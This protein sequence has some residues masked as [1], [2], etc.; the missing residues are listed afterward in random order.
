MHCDAESQR[1]RSSFI[2]EFVSCIQ[3]HCVLQNYDESH[4]LKKNPTYNKML[5]IQKGITH[6]FP[7]E[8]KLVLAMRKY[9]LSLSAAVRFRY[10]PTHHCKSEGWCKLYL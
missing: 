2:S 10:M 1:F 4:L 8:F 6:C 5:K 7:L 3:H 9:L